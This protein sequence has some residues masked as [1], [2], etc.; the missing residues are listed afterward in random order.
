MNLQGASLEAGQSVFAM[1]RRHR[2][3]SRVT[4]HDHLMWRCTVASGLVSR[5]RLGLAGYTARL[6][7]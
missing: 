1:R 3:L 5:E 7:E 6:Q 4:A 2:L